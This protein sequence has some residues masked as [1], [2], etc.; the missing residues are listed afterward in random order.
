MRYSTFRE[1]SNVTNSFKSLCRFAKRPPVVLYQIKQDLNPIGRTQARVVGIVGTICLVEA[2]KDLSSDFHR[3]QPST[4]RIAA[5]GAPSAGADEH[6]NLD[7]ERN[8][9]SP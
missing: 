7:Q 2:R 6:Q 9:C 8:S 5:P 3:S 1:F 4:A